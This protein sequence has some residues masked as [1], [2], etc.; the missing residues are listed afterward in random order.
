M[1]GRDSRG[2]VGHTDLILAIG[3]IRALS[4]AQPI[5][6]EPSIAGALAKGCG[7]L[8]ESV[9]VAGVDAV[10]V[11]VRVVPVWTELDAGEIELEQVVGGAAADTH[12]GHTIPVVPICAC[13]LA[14]P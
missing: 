3:E 2:T 1:V 5:V 14:E 8:S 7:V 4:L 11:G 9:G 13:G 6:S 10:F 12:P